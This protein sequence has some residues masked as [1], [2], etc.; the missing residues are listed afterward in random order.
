MKKC[1]RPIRVIV[2]G[3]KDE[4]DGYPICK[5]EFFEKFNF[6]PDCGVKLNWE[7]GDTGEENN[8]SMD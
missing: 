1:V 7:G 4:T 5:R 3:S 8:C 2:K 6:C